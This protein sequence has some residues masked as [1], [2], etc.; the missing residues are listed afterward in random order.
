ML[1]RFKGIVLPDPTTG[2]V[3]TRKQARDFVNVH[4]PSKAARER[5][6]KKAAEATSCK[7][8]SSEDAAL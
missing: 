4:F 5:T 7:Q 1:T 3:L 6:A 8:G 2:E